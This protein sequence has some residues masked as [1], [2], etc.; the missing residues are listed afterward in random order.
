MRTFFRGR[1]AHVPAFCSPDNVMHTCG[2]ISVA[3]NI[4]LSVS[5]LLLHAISSSLFLI[6][7]G[8]AEGGSYGACHLLE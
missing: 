2:N 5:V 8:V 4:I 7:A 6:S 1:D 3:C